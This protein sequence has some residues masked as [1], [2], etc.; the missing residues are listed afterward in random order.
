MAKTQEEPKDAK[1][2]KGKDAKDKDGNALVGRVKKAVKKSQRKLGEEK[3]EKEL[4]RTIAFLEEFQHK[5]NKA[6]AGHSEKPEEK[7]AESATEKPGKPSKPSGKKAAE[8]KTEKKNKVG[9]AKSNPP[10][11]K[12]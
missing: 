9:K 5:L 3:F 8:K 10:A 1:N 11:S 4:Q 12:K 6:P 7:K 2:K